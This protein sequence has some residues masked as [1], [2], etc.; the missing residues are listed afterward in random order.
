MF[1][2]TQE[3]RAISFL[4]ILITYCALDFRDSPVL[5]KRLEG[6]RQGNEDHQTLAFLCSCKI[7]GNRPVIV[8]YFLLSAVVFE[9]SHV[10]FQP[11]EDWSET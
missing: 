3:S 9:M 1:N 2:E 6:L 10:S 8:K 4:L 7:R 5:G 11:S